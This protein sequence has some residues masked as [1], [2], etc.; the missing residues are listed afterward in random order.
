MANDYDEYSGSDEGQPVRLGASQRSSV[1]W[2]ESEVVNWVA[3]LTSQRIGLS[4][5]PRNVS[6]ATAV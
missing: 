4:A 5:A 1:R 3:A 2:V 6:P